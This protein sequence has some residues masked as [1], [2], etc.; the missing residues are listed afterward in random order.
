MDSYG[1]RGNLGLRVWGIGGVLPGSLFFLSIDW[2]HLMKFSDW[3][4]GSVNILSID[5]IDNDFCLFFEDL[6]WMGRGSG[7]GLLFLR[8]DFFMIDF[9]RRDV[10]RWL[11]SGVANVL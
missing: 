7:L 10:D 8:D 2:P 4:L 3:G 6:R 1:F 9:F 5:L 11:R